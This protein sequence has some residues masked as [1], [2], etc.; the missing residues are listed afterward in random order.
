MVCTVINA[1]A[2]TLIFGAVAVVGM[3]ILLIAGDL[4]ETGDRF[5]LKLFSNH[6]NVAIVPLLIVSIFILI[7]ESLAVIS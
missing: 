1:T 4:T 6:L 7:M 3:I 5:N 2:G